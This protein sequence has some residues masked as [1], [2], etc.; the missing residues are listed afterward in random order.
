MLGYAHHYVLDEGALRFSAAGGESLR[1]S[2]FESQDLAIWD[3]SN[4]SLP[5]EILPSLLSTDSGYDAMMHVPE[6]EKRVF[7]AVDASKILKP[8]LKQ[9]Q[10]S[11]WSAQSSAGLN[12]IAPN[13][14]TEQAEELAILRRSQGYTVNVINVQDIYDEFSFGL[15]DPEA[16]RRY[17]NFLSVHTEND[18]I[19]VLL[20]GDASVDPRN[21][22][23]QGE[24][25]FVPTQLVDT[26]FL[27]SASDHWFVDSIPQDG[28]HVAIGRLTPRSSEEASTMVAKLKQR[29][30]LFENEVALAKVLSVSAQAADYDFE[31]WSNMLFSNLGYDLDLQ[32][33]HI[34]DEDAAGLIDALQSD[35]DLV[36]Y[37]GHGSV[38]MWSYHALDGEKALALKSSGGLP[39]MVAVT[40]FN[41]LFH[42]VY[43]ESLAES[44][45]KAK[46]G[47]SVAV[48]ASSAM[49]Y[50]KDQLLLDESFMHEIFSAQSQSLGE[51]FQMAKAAASNQD[52]RN[53]FMLFGDPSMPLR[54]S[55]AL[56]NPTTTSAATAATNNAKGAGGPGY[57]E[58][59]GCSC[60]LQRAAN[61]SEWLGLIILAFIIR[62]RALGRKRR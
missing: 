33:L 15:A 10:P 24:F 35:V 2:G 52:V 34:T 25:D 40:C 12:I 16:L 1:L 42:D 62:L 19:H 46:D 51:A 36:H 5:K 23:G 56:S 53:T 39:L 44:L 7:Y 17:I 38:N 59:S 29:P 21:F 14:F 20:F 55:E 8:A 60:S 47:G 32:S 37:A 43:S 26:A 13:S 18:L 45:L 48:V 57:H 22:L 30:L 49:T 11:S 4:P 9:D 6:G 27:E 58:N 61:Y 3:V 28:A 54:F 50:P 31:N 41:G